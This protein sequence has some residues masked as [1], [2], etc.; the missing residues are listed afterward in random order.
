[1]RSASF[2]VMKLI[3][4]AK[5]SSNHIFFENQKIGPVEISGGN[6][7]QPEICKIYPV[8]G[9]QI[10]NTSEI[11]NPDMSVLAVRYSVALN[12]PNNWVGLEFW[13][14]IKFLWLGN[15][16]SEKIEFSENRDFT[17]FWWSSW[18]VWGLEVISGVGISV[19][20][21]PDGS[22]GTQK[23]PGSVPIPFIWSSKHSERIKISKKNHS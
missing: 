4:S 10:G 21:A 11:S 2:G 22:R 14:S 12:L 9:Y 19:P 6:K 13:F 17:T 8:E 1:M 16:E 23:C 5:W 7:F 3:R 18:A 15:H 20:E